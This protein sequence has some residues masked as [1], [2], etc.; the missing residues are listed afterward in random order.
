MFN[1]FDSQRSSRVIWPGFP[2]AQLV[3]PN[4]LLG[5]RDGRTPD[6]P[7]RRNTRMI[8]HLNDLRHR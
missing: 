1:W 4:E 8:G 5:A 2:D 7:I 3:S 6:L